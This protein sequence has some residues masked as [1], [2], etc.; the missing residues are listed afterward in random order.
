MFVLKRQY[1]I[2]L[3]LMIVLA[4][5]GKSF[6]LT[7]GATYSVTLEKMNSDGTLTEV[8]TT[9][10]TADSQ[11]KITFNFT[12]VPTNPT[13]HFLVITVKDSKNNVVRRSFVPAPPQGGTT[14]L[15]VNNL[16]DKQ[17]DILQAASLVGSDD[18]I[19]I[20]FG[21]IF[22]RTPYLTDS[23]IQNI[24]YLGNECIINGFEKFLTDN[25]VTSSQL[26]AFKDAL[27]YN[28]NG[29]DLSDFTAL[30]KSAVDNP[31]QA[32]D[33]MSRAAG[34]I[35]DIFIDAAA[36]AGIDLALVLAADDAAGG[37]ADSGA[38][39]Q[40]FQN[41][42]SQF[43]T[44]I[45]QSMM[46][47]HM[48]LAFVRLAKEYAEAMTALNASGTQVETFNTAMSNLFTAMETLDKKYAKYFTDP[49]NNPMTQQVQQQMDSD[50]SQA[51]TTFMTAITSTDADI[52]QM[53]QNM[54]NALNISVSQLPSDV[55]KYYDYTGQYVNWPIPQVVVTN[56][57]AGILSAGGDLTY[58]RL[59]DS[60]YP[61]PDSMGWLGVCS[62]TNYADQQSCES[63]GGT[64]T[65]QRTDYTQM[66]FPLSFAALMGI[67]EDVNIAEM[68]RDYLYDQNN[69]QTNGQPTWEQERQAKLVLVNTLNAIISNIGGTTDGNTAISNA[70]K[71]ALVRLMLPPNPN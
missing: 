1:L 11:G 39:A 10:V 8:G 7:A 64:W 24:A 4:I 43:Q 34:L 58:T 33:D 16:S 6:A 53:R 32:E 22:T 31:A 27:A 42:S 56:W 40:Y 5:P 67:Q 35:A 69:P 28:A 26:T 52:A 3:F 48:R 2:I 15:G 9:T 12:D 57:V 50:Y 65:K 19:V 45:N 41:L 47:F 61:I 55:G 14:E 20:A 68:T 60:T 30:F 63:N 18:P 51:F 13:T 37:I 49:E 23:D 70:Q 17:T 54:A 59:D 29:K 66:G 44:A 46:T 71:K 21:L 62:D 36:E 25:G 38:G